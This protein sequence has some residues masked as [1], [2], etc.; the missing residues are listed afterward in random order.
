M[1]A[2]ATQPTLSR[3]NHSTE[4]RK[5]VIAS[6]IGTTIET[7]DF[8]LYGIAADLIFGK[9]YFPNEEPLTAT[10]A[11]FGTFLSALLP[12]LLGPRCSAILAIVSAVGRHSLPHCCAL[13]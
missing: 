1:R 11:A 9:L 7:Y 8:F 2:I 3:S 10:L 4:L 13:A 6:T 5:A 12:D